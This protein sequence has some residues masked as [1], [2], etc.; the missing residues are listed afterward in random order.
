MRIRRC[1]VC[2]VQ[3]DES[4]DRAG[5]RQ[6]E[7]LK[8]N[9]SLSCFQYQIVSSEDNFGRKFMKMRAG[10]LISSFRDRDEMINCRSVL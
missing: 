9:T 4:A 1:T 2:T 3:P 6:S 8:S 10:K 5:K 7:P